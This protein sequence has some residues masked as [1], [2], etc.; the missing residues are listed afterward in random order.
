[1]RWLLRFFVTETDRRAIESDLAELYELRR[2]HEGEAAAERW[3]RRQ[4]L[5]YPVHVVLESVRAA[6][7]GALGAMCSSWTGHPLQCAKPRAHARADGDNRAHR[8]HRPGATTAMLGVVRAVLIDPLP[9][10]ASDELFWIY[11][12]NPP[13]RFSLSVVDYRALESDHPAF[14]AVTAYH[15]STVTIT[16]NGIAG[17]NTERKSFLAHTSE[18]WDSRRSSAGSS[19]LRTRRARADRRLDSS[20]LGST[21]RQ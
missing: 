1:M 21:L 8:R 5:F 12:D 18:P 17:A 14:S 20:L 16:D 7:R 4:R 15:P 2:R 10:A 11:T 9:Y 3:L 19:I 13:Y 6:I